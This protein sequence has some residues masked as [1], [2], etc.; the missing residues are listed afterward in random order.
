M[1]IGNKW[2]PVRKVVDR[3]GAMVTVEKLCFCMVIKGADLAGLY[4]GTPEA[5]WDQASELSRQLHI[6]CKEKPFHTIL[7]PQ[8]ADTKSLKLNATSDAGLPVFYYVREG[9]A[10]VEGD[11]ALKFTPIPPCEIPG[12]GYDCRVAM[13]PL[14]R[15]EV[16]N[17][18]AGGENVP[19]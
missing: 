1:I 12:K 13:G 16:Q 8:K 15:S 10:A 14:Y 6:I 7:P 17:S 11:A 19:R 5:A 9:S 3:A 4:A 2:T 18:A